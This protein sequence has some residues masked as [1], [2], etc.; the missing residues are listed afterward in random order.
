MERYVCVSQRHAQAT[1]EKIIVSFSILEIANL[2]DVS[3]FL[4]T[5]QAAQPAQPM[6]MHPGAPVAP[7]M[8]PMM[9]GMTTGQNPLHFI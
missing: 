2:I 5:G 9:P 1:S 7:Q 6:M 4:F 3:V 8:A